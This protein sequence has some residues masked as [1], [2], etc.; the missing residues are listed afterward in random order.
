MKIGL[1][2]SGGGARGAY[3]IGVW[4]ALKEL[5]IDRYIRVIS[6]TS[7]GALN[8]V[9]FIQNDLCLAQDI[10]LNITKEKILPVNDKELTK[11]GILLSLGIRNINFIKKHIPKVILGGNISRDGLNDVMDKLDFK[12]IRM[13]NKKIYVACTELPQLV[14]KYFSLN[15]KGDEDIKKILLATSALPMIYEVEEIEYNKYLDGGI[16][17]N[18]PIQPVY[19]EQCDLIIVVGL[20]KENKTNKRLYPNTPII[21]ISPSYMEDGVLKGTLDFTKE[22]CEKRIKQ[23]YDDTMNIF[24]PIMSL[25][26]FIEEDNQQYRNNE[27]MLLKEKEESKFNEL[28]KGIKGI[29]TKK[30]NKNL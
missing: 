24:A 4:T 29:F 17:D 11:K 27:I 30:S 7:I 2:L 8:G 10:W 12:T 1:V 20:T 23:G 16:V 9:L 5:E 26:R 13:S 22:G 15:D 3:Q 28:V 21:D 19:G 14:P 6:G 18:S 25:T